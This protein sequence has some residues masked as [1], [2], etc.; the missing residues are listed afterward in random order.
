MN[1]YDEARR[2]A[3][4]IKDSEEY[5]AYKRAEESV[6][7]SE[8]VK[9]M[10]DDFHVRQFE[11]QRK[12]MLGDEPSEFE[13]KQLQKMVEVAS[14]DPVA[15]DFLSAELRFTLMMQDVSK[16]LGEVMEL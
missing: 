10:I 11:L 16:I 15:R 14:V 3:R 7:G 4:S 1:V 8:S 13:M 5:R 9:K 2:L 6:K 12:Q